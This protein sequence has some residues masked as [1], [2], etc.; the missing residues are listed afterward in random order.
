MANYFIV[1]HDLES[2]KAMPGFIW[3]IDLPKKKIPIGFAKVEKGDRWIE[4]A[5]HKGWD[6][7]QPCSI[8]TGF[9]ECTARHWYGPVPIEEGTLDD[10]LWNPGT[11]DIIKKYLK[12]HNNAHMIRGKRCSGYQPWHPVTVPSIYQMLGKNIQPRVAVAP[13][14]SDDFRTIREETRRRELDPCKIPVWKR[15]PLNEQEVLCI[16]VG[17]VANGSKNLGIE[18]I[19]WDRTRFPDMLVKINGEEVYL[20]LEFDSLGILGPHPQEAA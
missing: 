8:V 2:F 10:K 4:F 16:V 15:E 1:K 20:E 5:Y 7:D 9:Y 3:R 17:D 11:A 13:I 6:N 12:D 18:E 19:I 14:N